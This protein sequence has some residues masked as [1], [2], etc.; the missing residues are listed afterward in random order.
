LIIKQSNT[1]APGMKASPPLDPAHLDK[2]VFVGKSVVTDHEATCEYMPF[3]NFV[4]YIQNQLKM[5]VLNQ[6]GLDKQF[7]DIHIKWSPQ[8]GES[9]ADAFK[10]ALHDQLGLNVVSGR[11]PVEVLVVEKVK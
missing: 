4:G 1:D 2:D 7:Y 8:A 11:A 5:P 9:D 6:T 10:R 3:A